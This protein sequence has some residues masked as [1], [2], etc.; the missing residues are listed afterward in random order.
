[1]NH[2][3]FIIHPV[4]NK[5]PC[6]RLFSRERTLMKD[7]LRISWIFRKKAVRV[8]K[9]IHMLKILPLLRS[10][11]ERSQSCKIPYTSLFSILTLLVSKTYKQKQNQPGVKENKVKWIPLC[12]Q[13]PLKLQHI[14]LLPIL[15][16]FLDIL[17]LFLSFATIT[18]L[19][20]KSK[21]NLKPLPSKI[22]T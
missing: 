13:D 17:L 18:I 8:Y 3:V 9:I 1:M 12:L 5:P 19:Y 10:K 16:K 7:S 11:P 20:Q 15:W 2:P 6:I 4:N 21:I 22:V 14:G